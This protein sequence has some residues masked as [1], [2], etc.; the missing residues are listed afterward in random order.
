[1]ELI[2]ISAT[3][4]YCVFVW[5]NTNA[6]YDYFKFIL[7]KLKFFAEYSNLIEKNNLNMNFVDYLTAKKQGFFIKLITC[8]FCLTFWLSVILA[9]IKYLFAVATLSFIIYKS[10]VK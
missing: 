4:A 6:V 8:P 10:L 1:M 2:L 7:R 9:P 3:I 5:V